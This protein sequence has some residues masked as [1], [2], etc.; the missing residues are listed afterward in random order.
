MPKRGVTL[1]TVW[2]IGAAF[3]GVE[4]STAYNSPA[5]KVKRPGGKLELM[6]CVPT[7]QAAE[8][9]SLLLRVDRRQRASMLEEAP[10]IYYVPEHYIAYDGVLVRLDRL[11]PQ[12]LHDLLTTAYH[13]VTRK[14]SRS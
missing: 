1:N 8:P 9:G 4:K 5:L 7:N 13:F 3:P 2:K 14:R 6:A 11:T 10:D 12:L